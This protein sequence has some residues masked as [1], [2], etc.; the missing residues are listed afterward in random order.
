MHSIYIVKAQIEMMR[1]EIIANSEGE[2][3]GL[4]ESE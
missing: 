2:G 4:L 3:R 1:V